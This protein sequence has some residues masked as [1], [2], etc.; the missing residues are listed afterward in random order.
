MTSDSA[1]VRP[2]S[3]TVAN[4]LPPHPVPRTTAEL[5]DAAT[6]LQWGTAAFGPPVPP[7]ATEAAGEEGEAAHGRSPFAEGYANGHAPTDRPPDHPEPLDPFDQPDGPDPVRGLVRTAVVAQRLDDVSRLIALL[8]DSPDGARASREALR[9]A[10]VDRPVDEFT[11]LV[12]LLSAPPH[13]PGRA[14][15]A[16]RAAAEHRPIAEVG[17]LMALLHTPAYDEWRDSAAHPGE[18]AVKAAASTRSVEELVQL[19]GRLEDRSAGAAGERSPF[20]AESGSGILDG[21]LP[22]P[23]DSALLDGAGASAAAGPATRATAADDSDTKRSR[24][25]RI[26]P[27]DWFQW[28]AGAALLVCGAAHFP[29]GGGG[30]SPYAYGLSAAASV[31]CLVLSVLVSVRSWLPAL[32]AGVLVPGV[33]AASHALGWLFGG[34]AL[35]RVWAGSLAPPSLAAPAAGLAALVSLGALAWSLRSR[36]RAAH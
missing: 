13:T 20:A 36:M 8:E 6:S 30:A 2:Q 21:G 24:F 17:H 27:G 34:L 23:E 35:S 18:E 12:A 5:S 32:A 7:P 33:L 19:I 31:L 25:S 26:A 11:Q 1:H 10:A 14:D 29:L 22:D 16:I 3:P 15:E 28:A 9:V 4:S